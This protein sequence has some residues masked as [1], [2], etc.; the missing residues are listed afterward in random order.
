M[1]VKDLHSSEKRVAKYQTELFFFLTS[2]RCFC[3]SQQVHQDICALLKHRS[4]AEVSRGRQFEPQIY[5]KL[6]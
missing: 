4:L 5:V 6:D 2:S 1:I 3:L